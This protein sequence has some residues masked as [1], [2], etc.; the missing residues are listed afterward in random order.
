MIHAKHIKAYYINIVVNIK[1][2]RTNTTHLKVR[3]I[4]QAKSMDLFLACLLTIIKENYI[5]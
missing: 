3:F 2:V 1:F 4:A 5:L